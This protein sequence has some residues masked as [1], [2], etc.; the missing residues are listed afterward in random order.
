MRARGPNHVGGNILAGGS[1]YIRQ[2]NEHRGTCHVRPTHERGGVV[3]TYRFNYYVH[4]WYGS[5]GGDLLLIRESYAAA[6]AV[7]LRERR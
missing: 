6:F 4:T 2:P 5:K 7:F 1:A 3:W